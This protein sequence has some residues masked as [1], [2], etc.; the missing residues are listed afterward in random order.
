MNDMINISIEKDNSYTVIENILYCS[1]PKRGIKSKSNSIN[2]S[3]IAASI[4]STIDMHTT[5]FTF[6]I[7][8]EAS[9]DIGSKE[10]NI[11]NQKNSN[12]ISEFSISN[13]KNSKFDTNSNT[14]KALFNKEEKE[15]NEKFENIEN[16]DYVHFIKYKSAI[17]E[18]KKEYNTDKY[19]KYFS[20]KL[21]ENKSK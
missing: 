19:N 14:S 20:S 9:T 11:N 12:L 1:S 10:D 6:Y 17:K 21:D 8:K 16:E 13:F 7:V 3:D 18:N 2:K 15:K 4:S 5:N